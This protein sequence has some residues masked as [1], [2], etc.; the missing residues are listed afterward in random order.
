M[1]HHLLLTPS[2]DLIFFFLENTNFRA[3]NRSKNAEDLYF[4]KHISY[5]SEIIPVR[6]PVLRCVLFI[7]VLLFAVGSDLKNIVYI[8]SASSFISMPA[9]EHFK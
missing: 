2:E 7:A 1:A 6:G 8:N 9:P 4:R 5:L 3:K